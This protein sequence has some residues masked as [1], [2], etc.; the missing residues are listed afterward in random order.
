VTRR[1]SR[2]AFLRL[3]E[4]VMLPKRLWGKNERQRAH[5]GRSTRRGCA[6]TG[7]KIVV[8]FG[9]LEGPVA[10][11][12]LENQIA[13]RLLTDRRYRQKVDFGPGGPY[14][15]QHIKCVRLPGPGGKEA[16][17]RFVG[18]VA[19]EPPDP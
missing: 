10:L 6:W 15:R 17:R 11:D 9:M 13:E 19:C 5:V 12:R 4:E 3:L 2:A 14:W 18:D 16:R 8:A 1:R 7:P